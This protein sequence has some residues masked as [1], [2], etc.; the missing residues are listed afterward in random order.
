MDPPALIL[1]SNPHVS[2]YVKNLPD[3][4]GKLWL[5]E[6]FAPFGA[7]LSVNILKDPHGRPRHVGFVNFSDGTSALRAMLCMH[8]RQVGRNRF[9]IVQWQEPRFVLL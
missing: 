4:V 1:P 3:D 8:N 6:H 2:L 5:Y 9:L 7:I